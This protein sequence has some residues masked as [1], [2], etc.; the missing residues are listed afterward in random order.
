MG[1]QT[2]DFRYNTGATKVPWAAVGENYNEA[3]LMEII[4][5][6][7]QGEGK[8]YEKAINAV[9][10]Q[11]KKLAEES[12]TAAGQT[13]QL[14]E[15]TIEAVEK[16]IVIAEQ[17][18]QDMDVVM[19]GAKEATVQMSAISEILIKEAEHI[20]EVNQRVETISEVISN[21]SAASE[22][23]AAVSEEQ[24][25]QVQTMVELMSQFQI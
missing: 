24:T 3:D 9:W 7:M 6:L 8:A 10:K 15:T 1:K 16:G 11:V 13:T 5:F 18:A 22:E 21:N 2:S 19:V 25:A 12:A 20:Q 4:A 23:T 14:I 17:T